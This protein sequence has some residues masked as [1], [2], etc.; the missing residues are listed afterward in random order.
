LDFIIIVVV[1][2]RQS[3]LRFTLP[4]AGEEDTLVNPSSPQPTSQALFSGLIDYAGMFPPASLSFDEALINFNCYQRS[5]HERWILGKFILLPSHLDQLVHKE[6]SFFSSLYKPLQLS[7]VIKPP[8]D[9]FVRFSA[10]LATLKEKL[11]VQSLEVLL[12]QSIPVEYFLSSILNL[13]TIFYHENRAPNIFIEVPHSPEEEKLTCQLLDGIAQHLNQG[14]SRVGFKLRCGGA[15]HLIPNPQ[16]V[17]SV[18]KECASRSIPIKF[19]AGLHQPFCHAASLDPSLLEHHGYFNIFF[20]AFL[21]YGRNSDQSE[22]LT[23]ITQKNSILPSLLDDKIEWLGHTI[24][25]IEIAHI[26]ST[27]VTSFGSCSFNEPIEEARKL[28]WL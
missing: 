10:P 21:A 9:D 23:V 6:D 22:L 3:I 11:R 2:R 16:R 28:L 15:P 13:S 8:F 14:F 19:T 20:A 7:L 27:R 25:A 12:D 18:L 4:Q 24:S 1:L 5:S 26:R 17:A